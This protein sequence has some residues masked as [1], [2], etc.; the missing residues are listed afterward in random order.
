VFGAIG[1]TADALHS[2]A[3]TLWVAP[4]TRPTLNVTLRW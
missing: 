2:D 3:R 1:A 4:K